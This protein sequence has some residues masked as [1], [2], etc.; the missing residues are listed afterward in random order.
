M[1]L[2]VNYLSDVIVTKASLNL[3]SSWLFSE[4]QNMLRLLSCGVVGVSCCIELARSS[5]KVLTFF[6]NMVIV[7]GLV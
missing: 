7:S 3:Y 5:C 4:T 2:A 6:I 1:S